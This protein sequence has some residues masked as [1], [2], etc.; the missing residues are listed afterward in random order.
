MIPPDLNH[1]VLAVE[2]DLSALVDSYRIV[3]ME[4]AAHY[5]KEN[6][7]LRSALAR[8]LALMRTRYPESPPAAQREP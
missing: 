3:L 4:L 2:A 1:R 5:E 7:E 8:Q 6:A